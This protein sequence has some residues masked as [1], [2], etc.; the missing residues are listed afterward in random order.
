MMKSAKSLAF[1]AVGIAAAGFLAGAFAQTTL[2]IAATSAEKILLLYKM[3]AGQVL[4]YRGTGETREIR[5]QMGRTVEFVASAVSTDAFLA[6]GEKDGHFLL[7]VTVEDR[8]ASLSGDM[9]NYSTDFKPV[10]GKSFDMVLSPLGVEVDVTGAESLTFEQ[11]GVKRDLAAGF[12]IFFPDLPDKPVGVGDTWPSSYT[13]ETKEGPVTSRMEMKI[14]NSFDGFETVDGL[15]CARITSMVS[16]VIS[17][18]G[19]QGG[20][21]LLFKGETKGTDVWRFAP[22]EGLYVG[23]TSELVSEITLTIN[24][25]QAL[26]IPITQKRKGEIR[27]ISHGAGGQDEGGRPLFLNERRAE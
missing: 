18:Q 3:P 9:G 20:A 24:G 4:R 22:K 10:L 2:P 26:T 7:G 27:L 16:G 17:G 23:S 19:N 13:I 1:L 21:E 12:K 15:E 5:D 6:K 25:A 8:V 11:A 14:I